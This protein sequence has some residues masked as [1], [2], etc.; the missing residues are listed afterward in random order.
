MKLQSVLLVL[1][2][3]GF[4]SVSAQWAQAAPPGPAAVDGTYDRTGGTCTDYVSPVVISQNGDI[5]SADGTSYSGTVDKR[6]DFV[7]SNGIIDCAG[8]VSGGVATTD[9]TYPDQSNCS[10]TY[11]KQ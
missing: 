5:I 4:V 10:V 3:V 8:N 7:L 9:C 11:T 1:F 2:V 6:G